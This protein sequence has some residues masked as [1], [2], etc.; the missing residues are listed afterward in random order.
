MDEIREMFLKLQADVEGTKKSLKD[1]ETN[2]TRNINNNINEVV[3]NLQT[4]IEQLEEANDSQERRLDTIERTQRQR[5]LIIFG[6]EEEERGYDDLT[7]IML[8]ILNDTMKVNC[9]FFEMQA[10]RRVGR[11]GDRPRPIIFT[12]TTLGRKIEIQKK[13]KTLQ[14]T[15]YAIAEDYP[16]KVL[17]K[18]KSLIEQAKLEKEKGNRVLVK[19]DKLIVLPSNPMEPRTKEP[20][21]RKSKRALSETP[22]PPQTQTNTRTRS[23]EKKE[24]QVQKKNKISAYWVPSRPH[25]KASLNKQADE[26]T[27]NAGQ[28]STQ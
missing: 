8:S 27:T 1:L 28:Q 19:Y 24:T 5:N 18:R 26:N 7:Q 22:P 2:I 3:G 16:P 9:S 11:K 13:W 4:K 20:Q 10:I 12:L 6:V 17:E 25:A 14:N 21:T 15:N 23:I